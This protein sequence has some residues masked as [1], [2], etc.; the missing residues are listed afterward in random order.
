MIMWLSSA[1][2]AGCF[3]WALRV[4]L[5]GRRVELG[6]RRRRLQNAPALAGGS[7]RFIAD[8]DVP[9]GAP[10]AVSIA[11]KHE[12]ARPK[13]EARVIELIDFRTADD[14]VVRVADQSRE[15]GSRMERWNRASFD[16]L[17]AVRSPG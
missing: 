9:I 4:D 6:D 5:P 11:R 10:A 8:I 2:L 14:E 13:G 1:T 16:T 17:G 12:P 3:T 7:H 15:E